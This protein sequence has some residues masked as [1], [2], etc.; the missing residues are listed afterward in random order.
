MLTELYSYIHQDN[1]PEDVKS[2]GC[3]LQYLE[4]CNLLFKRGF[5]S[6]DRVFDGESEVMI[7]IDKGY[8]FFQTWLDTIL[9]KSKS[10]HECQVWGLLA[11]S[12]C[13]DKKFNPT[14][15]KQRCFISWQ[16]KCSIVLCLMV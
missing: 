4:A 5:L 16:S 10:Y 7:N 11:A 3:T 8:L 1:E 12:P 13:T 2:V 9:S 6:H 14:D 15:S